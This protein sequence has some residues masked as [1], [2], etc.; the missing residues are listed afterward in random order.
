[1]KKILTTKEYKRMTD[2]LDKVKYMCKCGHR[3]IIPK[4]QDKTLC[5]WCNNYVFRNKKEEFKFRLK[6]KM[7]SRVIGENYESF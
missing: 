3:N 6:E 7:I 2:E 1:M 5:S 4:W